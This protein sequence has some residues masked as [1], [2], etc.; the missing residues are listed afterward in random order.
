[1][2]DV[3]LDVDLDLDAD[4]DVD[5]MDAGTAAAAAPTTFYPNVAEFVA[6]FWAPL[7]AREWDAMDRERKWCSRWWLH[8]EAVVRLEAA[9]KAWE[10]L[11]LDPGTGASVWLHDHADPCIAA[12]TKP[13]GTFHRC[14]P[15]THA[16]YPP[17]VSEEPPSGMFDLPGS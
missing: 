14:G 1:M 13:H 12:L 16:V 9:W 8:V 3:D 5:P 11:R 2:T 7:Y 4:L 15:D 10:A 6:G 17:L